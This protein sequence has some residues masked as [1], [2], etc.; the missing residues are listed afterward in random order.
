[1]EDQN[2]VPDL[3]IFKKR[4]Q[5]GSKPESQPP[6]P[7]VPVHQQPYQAKPAPSPAPVQAKTTDVTRYEP[8]PAMPAKPEPV[9]SPI[10]QVVKP[11]SKD[12]S[13][14]KKQPLTVSESLKQAKGQLCINHPW[15]HA[16]ALCNECRLPYCYVDIMEAEGHLYCLNHIDEATKRR[17]FDDT[18]PEVNSFSILASI[19]FFANAILLGYF[20]YKQTEFIAQT[21]L[22]IGIVH[23]FTNLSTS[24]YIPLANA[25]LALIGLICAISVLRKGPYGIALGILISSGGLMIVLYEYLNSSVDYLFVSCVLYIFALALIAYSRMS[26]VRDVAD[27]KIT[28]PDVEWPKPEAF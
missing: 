2:Q 1:M 10:P 21:A 14:E 23:F 8:R 5:E 4:A 15:R 24:Y 17:E 12:E 3:L 13:Q 26:A 25:F 20:T 28:A 27:Q 16:Y 18:T 19:M 7:S 11:V 22:S 9:F 6:K